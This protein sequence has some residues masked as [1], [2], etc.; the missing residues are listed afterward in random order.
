[1]DRAARRGDA[2]RI[3]HTSTVARAV[4]SSSGMTKA[5][6]SSRKLALGASTIRTLTRDALATAAGGLD[7]IKETLDDPFLR[8]T[9]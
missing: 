2:P 7:A 6:T 3:P 9:H 8:R 1:M 4:H 5:K